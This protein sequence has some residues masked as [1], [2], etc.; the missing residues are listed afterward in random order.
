MREGRAEDG[1]ALIERAIAGTSNPTIQDQLRDS[2]AML[3][4]DLDRHRQVDLF[5]QARVREFQRVSGIKLES[6]P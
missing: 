6:W 1:L 4:A 3:K 2:L 5:N